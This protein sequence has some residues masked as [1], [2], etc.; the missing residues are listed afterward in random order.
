MNFASIYGDSDN[1]NKLLYNIEKDVV[2][3]LVAR[4]V[5][6]F[7]LGSELINLFNDESVQPP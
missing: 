2:V 7:Y 4:I 1:E 5:F 6:Q 3:V